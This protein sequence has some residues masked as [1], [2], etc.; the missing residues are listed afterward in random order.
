MIGIVIGWLVA[1]I[2]LIIL[3]IAMYNYNILNIFS[4]FT[5]ILLGIAILLISGILFIDWQTNK[6]LRKPYSEEMKSMFVRLLVVNI[7]IFGVGAVGYLLSTLD[8]KSEMPVIKTL[9]F[10][11]NSNQFL[12]LAIG[13][14]GAV[15][16]IFSWIYV[17]MYGI[18]ETL[19]EVTRQQRKLENIKDDIE[20]NRTKIISKMEDLNKLRVN[21]K[22]IEEKVKEELVR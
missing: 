11:F 18:R 21:T 10:I 17:D 8:Y 2:I 22:K 14:L 15:S 20:Q 9:L 19:K 5:I 13:L 4:L 7:I 16:S 1:G 12:K 6:K 3:S